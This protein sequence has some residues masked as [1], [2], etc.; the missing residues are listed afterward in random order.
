M[1]NSFASAVKERNEG[2][3]NKKALCSERADAKSRLVTDK[4]VT[5]PFQANHLAREG[6]VGVGVNPDS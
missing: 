4:S 2:P 6:Q 5:L 3:E 1:N